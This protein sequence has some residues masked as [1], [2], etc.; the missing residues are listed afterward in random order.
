MWISRLKVTNYARLMDLNI[1]VRGHL[2]IVGANDV[3]KTSLLRLLNLLLGSTTGQLYQALSLADLRDVSAPLVAEAVFV[4]FTNSERALFHR[5]ISIDPLT[6][7]ESLRVRLEVA[8]DPDDPEAV[9]IKRWFPERGDDR[10]APSREQ[11]AAIG[12][13]Y[14]PANRGSTAS[15]LD[16]PKSA[17][18][19]LLEG[20]DLGQ[21]RND[22]SKILSEFNT[23]L[24]SSDVLKTLRAQVAD[25]LSKAMPRSIQQDDLA[26]RTAADPAASVLE[27]VSMFFVRD[28]DYVPITEQS[29]GLRQLM[30]MALF[31]LAQKAANVI[32][33]DEPELHLHPASQRT[34]AELLT[35]RNNQKMV[36]THS[37]YIVQRFDPSQV[38]AIDPAGV[39]HQLPAEKLSEI[40]KL[41]AQWWSPRLLEALTARFAILVEG[42]AD[43][44]VVEAAAKALGVRLDRLGAVVFELDG[45]DK[46]RYVYKLLGPAGFCVHILGLVDDGKKGPWFGAIGGK[47]AHIENHQVWVSRAD[48]ED[49]YCAALTGPGVAMALI[50]AGVCDERSILASCGAKELDELT[51]EKVAS[52]C[53]KEKVAAATA[54]AAA[55]DATTAMKITSVAG[56]LTKLQELGAK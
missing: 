32:A 55:L 24:D 38:L 19:V 4:N 12:W 8:A 5:E 37:P 41:Q 36:A 9:V 2:V 11:L 47:P 14:L 17:L 16:G 27:E 49:E 43:R 7:T 28:G 42:V 50:T 54:V 23:K 1:E 20:L 26:L 46:F 31:D 39:C 15:Q 30:S 56:L 53:R 33:V 21:E 13:R 44:I 51:A 52:Y 10:G 6:K 22:L 3:G 40:E 48:L 45:A 25:H 29:D 35:S 34:A 18:R